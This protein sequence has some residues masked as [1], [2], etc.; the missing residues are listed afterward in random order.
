MG[1]KDPL[2]IERQIPMYV[3]FLRGLAEALVAAV[4]VDYFRRR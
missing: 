2:L 1:Q 4:V 3:E